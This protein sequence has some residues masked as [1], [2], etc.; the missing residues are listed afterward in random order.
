MFNF[1]YTFTFVENDNF[2]VQAIVILF[3]VII[4][5]IYSVNYLK[6]KHKFKLFNTK[7]LEI[8]YYNEKPT[9]TYSTTNTTITVSS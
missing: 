8:Y 5:I 7:C 3:Q 4:L 6:S 1:A 2:L 9:S